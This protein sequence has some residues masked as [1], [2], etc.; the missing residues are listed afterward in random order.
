MVDEQGI[1]QIEDRQLRFTHQVAQPRMAAKSAWSVERITGGR[2]EG[3]ESIPGGLVGDGS[4]NF[5]KGRSTT[6]NAAGI[7]R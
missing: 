7:A 2:L 1:D 6:G 5:G 3:H 4:S